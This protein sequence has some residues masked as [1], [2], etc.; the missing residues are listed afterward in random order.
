MEIIF[1]LENSIIDFIRKMAQCQEKSQKIKIIHQKKILKK[2]IHI[3]IHIKNISTK[4][5]YDVEKKKVLNKIEYKRM[6]IENK[7]LKKTN[8]I[9]DLIQK[10]NY[11]HIHKNIHI[12]NNKQIYTQS[13]PHIVDNFIHMMRKTII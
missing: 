1:Q 9:E 4:I 13:Y 10:N 8:K 2:F 12:R 11:P 7:N 5:Y 6:I 3:D